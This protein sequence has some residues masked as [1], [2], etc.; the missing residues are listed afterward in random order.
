MAAAVQINSDTLELGEL[1]NV[2]ISA[3]NVEQ[4][5]IFRIVIKENAQLFW[6]AVF[7]RDNRFKRCL[8]L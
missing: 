5:I 3:S 1:F 8:N 2:S 4:R 6:F 7:L